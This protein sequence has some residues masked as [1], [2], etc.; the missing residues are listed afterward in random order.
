MTVETSAVCK[1]TNGKYVL[2][3]GLLFVQFRQ[4]QLN[5]FDSKGEHAD[6]NSKFGIL[7]HDTVDISMIYKTKRCHSPNGSNLYNHH[8]ENIKSYIANSKF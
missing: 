3:T 8:H 5:S 2:R 7:N 4:Q 1:I 6:S